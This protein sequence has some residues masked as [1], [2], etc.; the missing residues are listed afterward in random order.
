MKLRLTLDINTLDDE[1]LIC[2]VANTIGGR[3][4]DS[5]DCVPAALHRLLDR[6]LAKHSVEL[7]DFEDNNL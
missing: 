5:I 1:R 2:S 3:N 4:P 6:T 7:L